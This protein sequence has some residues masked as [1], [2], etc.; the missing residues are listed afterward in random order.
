MW[1]CSVGSCLLAV[2]S[3]VLLCMALVTDYWLLAIGANTTAH[4]GLWQVCLPVGCQSPA[5]VTG[6]IQATRA[7]LILAVLATAASVLSLLFSVTSC[8]RIP[9]STDLLASIAAFTAGSCT[10][11]AMG[12]YTGESWHKNQDGQIQL[13]FEWSFY[14]GWA[15]LLLLALSG[16]FALVAHQRQVGY[17]RQ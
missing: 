17:E 1:A 4:S 11:V 12:V 9:V 5:H 16:T 2:S 3:L 7:F 13:T 15:A 6:Y 14:L 10:L 8:V